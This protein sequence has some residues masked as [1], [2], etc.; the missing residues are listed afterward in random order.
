M[1]FSS[2]KT[3]GKK[4]KIIFI[5]MNKKN[6]N[7]TSNGYNCCVQKEH[8]TQAILTSIL[9]Y[10]SKNNHLEPSKNRLL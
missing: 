6:G 5:W 10:S 4:V 3:K 1:I 7:T 8:S 9:V 2:I